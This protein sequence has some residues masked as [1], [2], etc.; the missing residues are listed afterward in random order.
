MWFRKWS[1]Q[2]PI[3][4]R[5]LS[6]GQVS[7]KLSWGE[8]S[9]RG[10][11]QVPQTEK[12]QLA[13]SPGNALQKSSEKLKTQKE[14]PSPRGCPKTTLRLC[15]RGRNTPLL[16]KRPHL[17]DAG[18]PSQSLSLFIIAKTLWVFH[19]FDLKG[20]YAVTLVARVMMTIL[21]FRVVPRM[22]KAWVGWSLLSLWLACRLRPCM[23]P[24]SK[25]HGGG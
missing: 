2:H 24:T 1:T 6:S 3:R 7:R 22:T 19:M 5:D 17:E 16:N 10:F 14:L 18:H 4:D 11:Y 20:N 13:T 25:P 8:A 21:P 9:G 15:W 23:C 12:G